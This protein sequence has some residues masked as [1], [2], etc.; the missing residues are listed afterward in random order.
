VNGDNSTHGVHTQ[1]FPVNG[2][3]VKVF[4]SCWG[5]AYT[6]TVKRWSNRNKM[7]VLK[8][9]LWVDTVIEDVPVVDWEFV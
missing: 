5:E 2:L 4:W 1:G 9:D 7:W 3:K 8:Y 6:A